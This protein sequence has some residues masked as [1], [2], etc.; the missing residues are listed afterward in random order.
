M[1]NYWGPDLGATADR[2]RSALLL[3][4]QDW[5]TSNCIAVSVA[6]SYCDLGHRLFHKLHTCN[7]LEVVLT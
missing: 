6:A 4:L 3:A 1:E 7:G 5:L 2:R